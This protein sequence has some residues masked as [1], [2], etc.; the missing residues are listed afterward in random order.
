MALSD[1]LK[2][3][4]DQLI[5]SNDYVLFMK[6]TR[7]RPVCGFSAAVTT[8]LDEY[9]DEYHAVNVLERADIREAIK[10]YSSW[11]TIPQLY[12][13]GEFIGGTDIVRGLESKG[14]LTKVLGVSG[15]REVKPP[16]ITL[17]AGAASQIRAAMADASEGSALRLAIDPRYQYE[18]GF[19]EPGPG[20][21][22]LESEGIKIVIDRSSARR[23]DGLS[24]DFLERPGG[25]GFRIENPNEPP[26]V[27][28]IGVRDLKAKMDAK[29]QFDLF[30]VRTEEERQIV[31]IPGA[32]LYD[33]EAD[34]Y[35]RG[36][37]KNRTLIFH[38]HHGQRSFQA[39]QQYVALGFKNVFV[40]E[41]GVDAWVAEID[42]SLTRY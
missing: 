13:R 41:G 2:K 39:A 35:I 28:P 26:R 27:K 12:V 1:E 36:L 18:L 37:D 15:A 40:V 17:T 22:V 33:L 38:C 42:P 31:K 8:I 19:D 21:L 6:G 23:A 20:D 34:S 14:E 10:E 16:K 7:E 32:Q 25:G 30:D 29:E 3:E 4:I 24:V 9:L 5:K 11:P